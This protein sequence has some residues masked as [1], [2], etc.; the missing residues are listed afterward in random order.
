MLHRRLAQLRDAA[1]PSRSSKDESPPTTEL[2][3]I[4]RSLSFA[5]ELL[6][7]CECGCAHCTATLRMR[8]RSSDSHDK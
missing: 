1:K 6:A 8:C 3:E 4:V 7:E 2:Y 5:G